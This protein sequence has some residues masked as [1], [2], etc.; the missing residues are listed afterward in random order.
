M[1]KLSNWIKPLLK[2]LRKPSWDA[3]TPIWELNAPIL[4]P[5][6]KI[7]SMKLL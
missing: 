1:I 2:I 7:A 5:T 6:W 4:N 3:G